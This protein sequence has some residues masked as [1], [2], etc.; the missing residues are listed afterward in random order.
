MTLFSGVLE[1][2]EYYGFILHVAF[3]S[4][5]SDSQAAFAPSCGFSRHGRFLQ[6]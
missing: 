2:G 6:N 5:G 3:N 1:G 4:T